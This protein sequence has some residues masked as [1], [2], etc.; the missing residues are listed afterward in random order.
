M[1]RLRVVESFCAA[2]HLDNYEGECKNLHG[3]NF[4]VELFITGLK[5]DRAEML[6]DFRELKN[7]L[8]DMLMYFD[9]KNLN[10]IMKCNPTAENIAKFIF[11]GL[12]DIYQVEKVRVWE[13]ENNW[14]EYYES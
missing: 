5:L 1:F 9:H 12:R 2:H 11:D 4:K 14:C 10:E 8:K 13:T 7:R 3:H 6:V